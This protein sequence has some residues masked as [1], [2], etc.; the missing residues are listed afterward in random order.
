MDKET[1]REI[2]RAAFRSGAE[3]E[4]LLPVLKQRCN[5]EEYKDYARQ[6]GL[7]VDGIDAALVDKVLEQ[8]PELDAEVEANMAVSRG[9]MR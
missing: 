9:A 3:L 8:F 7:A 5:A 4:E 1:A 6:V 2:I